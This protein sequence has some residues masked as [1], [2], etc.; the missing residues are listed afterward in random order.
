MGSK[1]NV[2]SGN[3]RVAVQVG[4]VHGRRATGK[5]T[6][7]TADTTAGRTENVRSGNARVGRQVDEIRGGLTIRR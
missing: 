1:H 3:D 4:Q 2:A 6:P 7:K 5:D